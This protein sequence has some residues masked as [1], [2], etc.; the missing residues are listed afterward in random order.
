M[1]AQAYRGEMSR[2]DRRLSIPYSSGAGNK[3]LP[4]WQEAETCQPGRWVIGTCCAA[5]TGMVE[6]IVSS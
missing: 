5:R 2:S 3:N 1:G 4:A 6:A